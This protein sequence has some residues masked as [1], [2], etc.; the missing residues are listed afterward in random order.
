MN[1]RVRPFLVATA[2]AGILALSGCGLLTPAEDSATEGRTAG[3]PVLAT[4]SP[5]PTPSASES[6][7]AGMSV[8]DAGDI[9]DVCALLSD[10]E[11]ESLTGRD[12]TQID[13]DGGQ[14]GDISRY[15]QWQLS[16]G[17]LAVFLSRTTAEEF[18]RKNTDADPVPGVGQDAYLLA[19]HLMVLYGTV[20]VDVYARGGSDAENLADAKEVVA[21]LLPR[22]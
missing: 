17:Q 6:G 9:P 1:P 19:G 5:E 3:T 13:K 20:H 4:P 2:V 14:P 8:K 22:I 18:A 12:I 15:C 11:V 16:A 10:A 21:V 7:T